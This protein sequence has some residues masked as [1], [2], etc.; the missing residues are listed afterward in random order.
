M[1]IL[2]FSRDVFVGHSYNLTN[3]FVWLL[4]MLLAIGME[5]NAAGYGGIQRD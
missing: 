3:E 5:R 1:N 4:A 2:H